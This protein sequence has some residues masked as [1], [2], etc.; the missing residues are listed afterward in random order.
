MSSDIMKYVGGAMPSSP[1]VPQVNLLAS[2]Q[3]I[4]DETNIS[5]ECEWAGYDALI[6]CATF[7]SN[8][9][10]SVVVPVAWF[11]ETTSTG[12]VLV[13]DPE[14]TKRYGVWQNGSSHVYLRG[15]HPAAAH[16]GVQ[17]FGVLFGE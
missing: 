13:T 2:R 17:I 4:S 12:R 6:V 7:G 10:A 3:Y 11:A 5:V 16:C 8:I 15:A 14:N 9:E 1:R